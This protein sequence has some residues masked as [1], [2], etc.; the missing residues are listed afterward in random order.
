MSYQGI[1]NAAQ[2]TAW[3]RNDVAAA[4]ILGVVQGITEF[5]PISSS[6]HL[7]ILP[8]AFQWSSPVLNSLPFAVALHVGT[9]LA[10]LMVF[11]RDVLALALAFLTSIRERDIQAEPNRRLAWLLVLA[12]L[13]AVVAGLL[14]EEAAATVLRSPWIIAATLAGVGVILWIVDARHTGE[15]GCDH[16]NWRGALLIGLAQALAIVPGVSRSGSTITMG[17]LLGLSR[18][19]AARFSFLLMAPVIFGAGVWEARHLDGAALSGDGGTIFVVGFLS[20]LVVGY[21]CIRVFLRYLQRGRLWPLALYRI[22][23]AAVIVLMLVMR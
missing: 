21:L 1:A 20:A 23:L 9:L 22:G 2:A 18:V 14:L 5:L 19:Q 11:W 3:W 12:T 6:G 15:R 13:P 4:A 8:W 7:A 16:L 10:V 17:M